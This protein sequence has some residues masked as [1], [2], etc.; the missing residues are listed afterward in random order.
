MGKDI[1]D[2]AL[3]GVGLRE[4][5][6]AADRQTPRLSLEWEPVAEDGL[7]RL[8]ELKRV[9][10]AAQGGGEQIELISTFHG[11]AVG[12]HAAGMA[13]LHHPDRAE[14]L[15][16]GL[17]AV[18]RSAIKTLTALK[19]AVVKKSKSIEDGSARKKSNSPLD[20]MTK[21]LGVSGLVVPEGYTIDGSGVKVE[22][23]VVLPAPALLVREAFGRNGIVVEVAFKDKGKWVRKMV[24]RNVL[25]DSKSIVAHLNNWGLL[26]TSAN[27]GQVVKFFHD[28]ASAND[29]ARVPAVSGSGWTDGLDSFLIGSEC[30]GEPAVCLSQQHDNAGLTV[31]GTW[32]GYRAAV[33]KHLK[34]HPKI[35][36]GILAACA[37]PLLTPLQVDGF[38]FAYAGETS[39]G[40]GTAQRAIAAAW[41][42][43][44]LVFRSW[45][46][47][48]LVG[49]Y[50]HLAAAGDLPIILEDT[51][52]AKDPEYVAK[53]LY[54]VVEGKEPGKGKQEG[55]NRE[56]QKWHTVLITSGET[57]LTTLGTKSGGAAARAIEFTGQTFN[58]KASDI[59][60]MLNDFKKHYGHLIRRVVLSAMSRPHE[61][62]ELHDKF[63]AELS[64]GSTGGV[65]NRMSGNVATMMVAAKVCEDVGLGIDFTEAL[66]VLREAV[67]SSAKSAD[68]P[69]EACD[70]LFARA[71]SVK[72]CFYDGDRKANPPHGGWLGFWKDDFAYESISF[73]PDVFDKWVR[74]DGFSPGDIRTSLTQR[75]LLTETRCLDMGGARLY[76]IARHAFNQDKK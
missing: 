40:K 71:V 33:H 62:R 4:L 45:M 64:K 36:C 19:R 20:F 25:A 67:K 6:A 18:H 13:W 58:G 70:R 27:G 75:N 41:G 11:D 59:K 44:Y 9:V 8:K 24:A 3:A 63:S 14:S 1:G 2:A 16:N 72:T 23:D 37:A 68:R 56:P 65:E 57:S 10:L 60:P 52:D 55:G 66:E 50:N 15:L 7:A 32:E 49:L 73:R 42:N 74:E 21:D 22:G 5:A 12:M 39:S 43:P 53:V 61:L 47:S 69:T 29:L 31:A 46:S 48:S 54:A 34:H 51:K 26:V 30:L 38:T 35:L 17:D 76:T 28:F